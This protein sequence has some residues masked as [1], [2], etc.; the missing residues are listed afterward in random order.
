MKRDFR[1]LYITIDIFHLYIRVRFAPLKESPYLPLCNDMMRFL[2]DII[3]LGDE[4][5]IFD[6]SQA[7]YRESMSE[8][9]DYG[10]HFLALGSAHGFVIY[11]G[12]S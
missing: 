2:G 4:P 7:M 1:E 5:T 6:T 11:S 8:V 9:T 10:K 12:L 3:L